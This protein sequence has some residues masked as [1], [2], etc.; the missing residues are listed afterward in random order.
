MSINPT[1]LLGLAAA[2]QGSTGTR[3]KGEFYS[4]LPGGITLA[5]I[6]S[7]DPMQTI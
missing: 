1:V 2:L 6:D 3:Q 5:F 4:T 7:L